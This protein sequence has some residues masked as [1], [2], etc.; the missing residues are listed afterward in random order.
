MLH[1]SDLAPYGITSNSPPTHSL[2][3]NSIRIHPLF[4]YA[5]FTRPYA[6]RKLCPDLRATT[7]RYKP[8][9]MV[10]EPLSQATYDRCIPAFRLATLFL[11][12]S[13]YFHYCLRNSPI[14]ATTGIRNRP[15]RYVQKINP[16]ELTDFN[17]AKIN[18]QL[19]DLAER[20]RYHVRPTSYRA[21][22]TALSELAED[23]Y[24][25][26]LQDVRYFVQLKFSMDL[27]GSPDWP[28]LHH[29]KQMNILFKLAI[30]LVYETCHLLYWERFPNF[31]RPPIHPH[32]IDQDPYWD[33]SEPRKEVGTAWER[34]FFGMQVQPFP[35]HNITDINLETAPGHA[36]PVHA[37]LMTHPKSGRAVNVTP[38]AQP[39][40]YLANSASVE[41]F[42]D[43]NAWDAFDKSRRW[44]A[45]F[46]NPLQLQ[47]TPVTFRS[48]MEMPDGS[49]M[50]EFSTSDLPV[51]QDK[52]YMAVLQNCF[53]GRYNQGYDTYGQFAESSDSN[54]DTGN[55]VFDPIPGP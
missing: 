2:D 43:I 21:D 32:E 24:A 29:S 19:N 55:P 31:I 4:R 36:K 54:S 40:C 50:G 18:L 47:L 9:Q 44:P 12:N 53:L 38:F 17:R 22:F 52:A 42:F 35:S 39:D 7:D 3:L 34:W 26:G 49:G 16:W 23:W 28:N 30:D 15:K 14:L 33:L 6:Y 13:T 5:N 8:F 10:Q 37:C 51:Q 45:S 11:G 41:R 20:V 46:D 27:I 25:A 48:V 1:T